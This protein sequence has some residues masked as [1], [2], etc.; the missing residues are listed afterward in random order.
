ME[1]T[2]ETVLDREAIKELRACFALALDTRD[3]ALFES[4]FTD[5]VDVDFTSMGVPQRSMSPAEFSELFNASFR[6][7]QGTQ[8]L[9]GNFLID[10]A[11]DSASCSSYLLGHHYAPETEGGD[12]VALR[13]RYLD[14]LVRTQDGWKI[15]ATT[16]HVFSLTG[17][18]RI[19]G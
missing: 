14:H 3:W 18:P 7:S 17:N 6:Q 9:Y 10:I 12:Q 11:G 16:L 4:L 13:A 19:F 8:Q 2:L 15:A 1:Q 5:D